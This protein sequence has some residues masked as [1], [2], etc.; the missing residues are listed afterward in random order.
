MQ[1]TTNRILAFLA[2]TALF[3]RIVKAKLVVAITYIFVS[4]WVLTHPYTKKR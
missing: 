2:V 3:R 1:F 4:D